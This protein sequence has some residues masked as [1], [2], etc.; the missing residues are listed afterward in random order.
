VVRSPKERRAW[1]SSL[2]PVFSQMQV[3]LLQC[4]DR[5]R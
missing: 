1:S 3:E 2:A 4:N 5:M